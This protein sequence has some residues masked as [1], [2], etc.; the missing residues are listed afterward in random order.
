M[1]LLKAKHGSVR[2]LGENPVDSPETLMKRLGYM[3]EEDSLPKWMRVGDMLDFSR[4]MYP[5]WDDRYS[6]DLCETFDLSRTSKLSELS[7]GATRPC[8]SVGGNRASTGA[9]DS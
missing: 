5:T 1:G 4:A 8:R 7:K 9:A 6:L 3:T 2:V